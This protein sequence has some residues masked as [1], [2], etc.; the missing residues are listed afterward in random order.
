MVRVRVRV[1]V[2]VGVGW[3]GGGG[4]FRC[5]LPLEQTPEGRCV[6]EPDPRSAALG[7]APGGLLFTITDAIT[8]EPPRQLQCCAGGGI[9]WPLSDGAGC[10][11]GIDQHRH[12]LGAGT[13]TWVE[14]YVYWLVW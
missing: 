10:P 1:M 14:Q 5:S 6:P 8:E 13:W 4:L 7:G 11:Q 3:G 12:L 2:G 9:F